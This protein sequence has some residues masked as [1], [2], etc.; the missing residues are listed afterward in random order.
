M[1]REQDSYK[2][3]W[4]HSP[5]YPG[6]EQKQK[7]GIEGVDYGVVEMMPSGIQRKELNVEGM[8]EPSHG[9][10]VSGGLGG[11]EGPMNRAPVEAPTNVG[12]GRDVKIIIPLDELI[13]DHRAVERDGRNPQKNAE[14]DIQL[15]ACKECPVSR[16][17]L[18][19]GLLR[20]W[21]RAFA[22]VWTRLTLSTLSGGSFLFYLFH[23][24]CD[25]GHVFGVRSR[26][27]AQ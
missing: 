20:L 17:A 6:Q 9:K 4:S 1:N 15:R 26:F 16:G 24:R 21:A 12:I 22:R 10:P 18:G 8:R 5:G 25:S 27:C 14:D 11:G 7:C 19:S 23:A 13:P 3:T 2:Q